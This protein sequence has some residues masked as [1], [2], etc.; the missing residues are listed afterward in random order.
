MTNDPADIHRALSAP[1]IAINWQQEVRSLRASESYRASD[2][3]R[4]LLQSTQQIRSSSL[5]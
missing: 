2:M 4:G 1:I 3:S 5:R